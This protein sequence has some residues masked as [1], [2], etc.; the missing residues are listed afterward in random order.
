MQDIVNEFKKI[1]VN[2]LLSSSKHFYDN[3]IRLHEERNIKQSKECYDN[4]MNCLEHHVVNYSEPISSV[5]ID[6]YCKKPGFS[7]ILYPILV[8]CKQYTT[9][10]VPFVDGAIHIITT[11]AKDKQ[12]MKML[13]EFI[14][15]TPHNRVCYVMFPTNYLF[16]CYLP[17]INENKNKQNVIVDILIVSQINKESLTMQISVDFICDA[18]HDDEPD[19]SIKNT[20][21]F[22][23]FFHYRKDKNNKLC[24]TCTSNIYSMGITCDKCKLVN[25][26]DNN[27]KEN[28]HKAH[29]KLCRFIQ[30][31]HKPTH[32]M[33]RFCSNCK[34][35]NI[36]AQI[37]ECDLVYYCNTDCQNKDWNH[38]KQL[39]KKTRRVK[40]KLKST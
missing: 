38:H 3:I 29:K 13:E 8:N 22:Y 7:T 11:C 39:C 28:D 9:E 20:H 10:P 19:I 17:V 5:K 31:T 18:K 12:L 6:Y 23:S 21:P 4:A 30:K 37:C 27:C 33:N 26:C 24:K 34:E 14:N 2:K 36:K 1:V 32:Y 40:R 25:Y 35:F 16:V 15:D